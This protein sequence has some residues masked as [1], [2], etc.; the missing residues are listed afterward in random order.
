MNRAYL[1]PVYPN[2][3]KLEEIRYTA[4]RFVQYIQHFAAI[5]FYN[6]ISKNPTKGMGKLANVAKRIATGIIKGQRRSVTVTGNKSSCPEIKFKSC[7]AKIEVSEDSSYDYWISCQTQF[8]QKH[9]DIK[10]IPAHSI[11][12]LNK[13]LTRSMWIRS[14]CRF[15]CSLY[16][17]SEGFR[18]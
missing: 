12:P 2:S 7:P 14:T 3:S 10:R 11:K 1:L 5:L 8:P 16:L 13:S 15:E 6:Q 18:I 17:G 4:T 9:N